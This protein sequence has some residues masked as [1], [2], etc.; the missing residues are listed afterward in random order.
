MQLV[1]VESFAKA[2]TIQKYL[3][4]GNDKNFKVVASGGHLFDL[5]NTGRTYGL[6]DTKKFEPIYELIAEKSA[7]FKKL[8]QEVKEAKIVWLAADNDREGEAIAW[9]L[10]RTLRSKNFRRIVF[11]EITPSAIKAAT[12]RPR[13]DE[14]NEQNE[15]V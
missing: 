4:K 11:N 2:K 14:R 10:Q 15:G 9:H 13:W 5:S 1:I 7:T 8:K 12:T 6:H 3:N